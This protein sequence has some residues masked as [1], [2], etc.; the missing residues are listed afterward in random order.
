MPWNVNVPAPDV[1]SSVN[2]EN[3]RLKDLLE[4]VT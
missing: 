1:D 2:R 3:I 4:K